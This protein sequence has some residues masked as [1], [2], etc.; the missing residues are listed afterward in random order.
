MENVSASLNNVSFSYT[1][2]TTLLNG[3]S[4]SVREGE[5]L[6]IIG[7]NGSGKS[8]LIKLMNGILLPAGGD[9]LVGGM[10]TKDESCSFDIRKMIGLVF[11]NPDNQIVS[12]TVE[13]DVAFALENL[14]VESDMI[15]ASVTEALDAVGMSEYRFSSTHH[16]SGG[17]KQRIAIAG[18][19]AM[20]PKCIALD[21]PTSMLDPKGRKKIIETVCGLNRDHGITTV[22]VTHYMEEAALAD[23]IIVLH[24]GKI[25][26]QGTPK[27]I[28]RDA[29]RLWQIELD[30]P[31]IAKLAAALRSR[32]LDLPDDILN[33]DEL[34]EALSPYLNGGRK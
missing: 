26:M 6:A 33:K 8:T 21:E 7:S 15:E 17:Q 3:I 25:Y 24:K 4:L 29:E 22:L 5:S 11:Q 1:E 16:L 34:I 20:R 28:F 13:E 19:L 18:I 10:N 30:I 32:G 31:P 9:V 23:R 14:G 2:N 27:E 12:S